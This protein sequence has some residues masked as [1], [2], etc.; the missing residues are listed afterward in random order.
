MRPVLFRIP[1]DGVVDV[2]PFGQV[3][4]F[5][6]GLMFTVWVAFAA[7]WCWRSRYSDSGPLQVSDITTFGLL[8]VLIVMAPKIAANTPMPRAT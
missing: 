5:G 6:L 3:P 1:I 4:L 2:G 8:G 7:L